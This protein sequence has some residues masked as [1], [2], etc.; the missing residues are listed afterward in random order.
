MSKSFEERTEGTVE[1][2]IYILKCENDF[3]YIG[4]SKTKWLE[5]RIRQQFGEKV[6]RGDAS[7]FCEKHKPI[8]VVATYDL[9]ILSYLEAEIIE[10]A[11]TKIYVN[12]FGK[13][14]VRGGISCLGEEEK[15]KISSDTKEEIL[16]IC[17]IDGMD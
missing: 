17:N 12:R 8:E 3:Y 5:M 15:K 1:R 16:G 7:A 6:G 4:E 11:W 13:D 2:S 14:K 9:G 10:N